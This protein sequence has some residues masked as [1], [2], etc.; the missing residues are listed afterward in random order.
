MPAG[1]DIHSKAIADHGTSVP[2]YGEG[3]DGWDRGSTRHGTNGLVTVLFEEKQDPRRLR[4]EA[5][6]YEP[7]ISESID[8]GTNGTLA[9][10]LKP[11]SPAAV[12]QGSVLDAA[13]RPAAD[14]EVAL[15]TLDHDVQLFG[16]TFQPLSG[17]PRPAGP[18]RCAGF[19]IAC[20]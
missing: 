4:I 2:G 14:V 17:I 10:A 7:F 19:G 5:D 20:A 1:G 12:V 15:L 18:G 13:G 6:G 9:A 16:H 3:L 11:L 8:P